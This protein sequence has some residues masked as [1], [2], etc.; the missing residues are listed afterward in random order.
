MYI[1]MKPPASGQSSFIPYSMEH[2]GNDESM[3]KQPTVI[4][5]PISLPRGIGTKHE[6][7]EVI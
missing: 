7:Q 2:R 1:C 5:K 6:H 3:K 4:A